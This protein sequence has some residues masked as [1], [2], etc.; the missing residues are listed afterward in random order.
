MQGLCLNQYILN[1]TH[2]ELVYI[3]P[4]PLRRPLIWQLIH[5]ILQPFLFQ[6]Q[7]LPNLLAM[8]LLGHYY[9]PIFVIVV[10]MP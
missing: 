5:L 10:K 8:L 1:L 2:Q 7:M 6:R 4:C 9:L 3:Q